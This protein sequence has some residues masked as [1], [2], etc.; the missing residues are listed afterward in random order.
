MN[1]QQIDYVDFIE[2]ESVNLCVPNDIAIDRDGWANW[3]NDPKTTRFLD[4]GLFP[5]T[6]PQ[7][8]EFLD[9]L[10]DKNR[11]A[12]LIKPKDQSQVIGVVSLSN[13]DFIRSSANISIVIGEQ[14]KTRNLYALESMALITEHGFEKLGMQRIAA[15]QAYPD[16]SK[17]NKWME[18]IG[19]RAEGIL[20]SKFVKGHVR[21]SVITLSC[22]YEDYLEIKN[23]RDEEYWPGSEKI[24][25]LIKALPQD[26]Y[27]DILNKAIQDTSESYFKSLKLS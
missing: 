22:L 11:L 23:V 17:W 12:L 14:L 20:R 6:K 2:G 26:G 25:Q 10:E 27:A 7:Q 13:I 18:L 21:K 15:G 24:F 3:F 9:N 16:L 8:K 5:N 19:Y 1:D 4:Q